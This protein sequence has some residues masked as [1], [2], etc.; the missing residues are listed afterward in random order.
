MITYDEILDQVERL[1]PED[2]LRLMERIAASLRRQMPACRT[3]RI[4]ELKGLGKEI[5]KDIDVQTYIDE[6][7]ESWNG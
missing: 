7:R 4:T 2:Q 3:H 5:W 6:E 1:S